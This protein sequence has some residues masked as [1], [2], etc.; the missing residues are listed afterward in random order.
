MNTASTTLTPSTGLDFEHGDLQE[1]RLTWLSESIRVGTYRV[2]ANRV[3]ASIIDHA[4]R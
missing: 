2:D 1:A 4:L 3:A